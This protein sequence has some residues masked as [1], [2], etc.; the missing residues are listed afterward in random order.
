MAG[1]IPIYL[2]RSS[3]FTALELAQTLRY[4]PDLVTV[5]ALLAAVGFCAPNRSGSAWLDRHLHA[6]P[7]CGRGRGIS[8]QQSL[9]DQDFPVH[10]AGQSSTAL[11]GQRLESLAQASQIGRRVAG[12]GGRPARARPGRLPGEPG[13]SPVRPDSRP[14]RNS[15]ATRHSYECSTSPVVWSMRTSP[16]SAPFPLGRNQNCGYFVQPDAPV[17]MP[18]DGPLLPAEWTAEINYL[19]NT[20]GTMLLSLTDGP[21]TKVTVHPGL[22]RVY[23]RLSG[24]E[25][26]REG[27]G[28]H[29]RTGAMPGF[30]SGGLHRTALMMSV[31]GGQSKSSSRRYI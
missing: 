16:G 1:Q 19:A 13:E 5:L 15:G 24:A 10:L 2:M 8:G 17:T 12:S 3:A 6:Q 11:R 27:S 26:C 20:D 22:N 23:V 31:G 9:L 28:D 25:R 18:L 14:A 7:W 29:S 30:G 4:L 21:E